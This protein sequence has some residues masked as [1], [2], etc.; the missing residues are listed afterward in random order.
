VCELTGERFAK[1]LDRVTIRLIVA[2][3]ASVIVFSDWTAAQAFDFFGLFG[4]DDTPPPVSRA[5]IPYVLTVEVTGDDGALKS[6]VRDASSLYSLRKDAPADGEALARRAETD[7][8]PVI[9]ALW[10]AGYYN[11]AATIAIDRATLTIGSS[12]I[13]AFARAAEAYRN[14][15]AAPVVIKVDPGPLFKLRS[16]RVVDALGVEFPETELP[17]RIVG[18]KPGDPAAASEIRAAETRIIDYFRKQGRP[19]AKIQSVAPVVDHAQDIMDVTIMAAPGLIA[20][21]GEATIKG[22]QTFDPA[23]VRSFLYIRPG[24]PYSPAAVADARNS[25]RQIPA[26]GGVRITEGTA[27]DAYGRLPY[28]IDVEGRL[29]YAFGASMKYSTTNGPEGQVYWEDR[30]VFGGAERLRLQADVFY[31]PPWFIASQSLRNFSPDDIGGRISASFLKPALWGTTNDLL[32]DALAEKL[33]TSGAGFVGYQ[34]EDADVTTSLR[35]RF[36]QNFWIQAGLEGQKGDATDALGTVNYTLVG[37]PVSANLDTTD[38]KLDPTRGVRVNVS[39]SGFGTFLGSSLDLVQAKARASAYYSLDADSRFV[40]AGR[41]AAGAMGGPQLDEIPANWRFYA[42]G[43]GSVRGY[44]YNE[45]GP[46]VFWGA[47][48]GGRSVFDASAELRVKVTDTIGVVPFFDIGNAFTSNFPTFNEPLFSAV[49]LGLRYY[50]SVGPIRL[51]VAFPLERHAGTGP[52]A[53]Y[54]SIGQSF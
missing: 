2:L 13:A 1:Q 28:Q 11:A 47:V 4:S 17:Q 48:V 44:A 8:A 14:R 36:N 23:I 43:G 50:T 49:G 20:P 9:D 35:H 40:L 18:L 24:D 22:P 3:A 27:L 29:P 38:S 53:V 25:V 5:S 52:V 39:A 54:V 51:D 26:V 45:L 10:G 42:G 34:A 16:V 21:F 32:I 7:L 30:N 37:V 6:A 12:D 41:I 46:T 15:S 33:S 19:L 31:A